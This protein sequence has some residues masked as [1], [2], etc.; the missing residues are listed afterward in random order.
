MTLREH[1]AYDLGGALGL[2]ARAASSVER[3]P[4]DALEWHQAAEL[5]ARERGQ[6][7]LPRVAREH[8]AVV[9]RKIHGGYLARRSEL[10][11][12]EAQAR[13]ER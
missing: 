9:G 7:E 6:A 1:V 10:Q 4:L 3:Q 13:R 12:V 8:R 2:H 11:R 5:F